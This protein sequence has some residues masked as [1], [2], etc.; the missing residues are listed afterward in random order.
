MSDQTNNA[1]NGDD[2][3]SWSPWNNPSV[4]AA[5]ADGRPPEDIILID[6]PDCGLPGHYNQGSHFTCRNC[7]EIFTC[8]TEEEEPPLVGRW[9]RLG[10]E[11]SLADFDLDPMSED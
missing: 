4:K 3:H 5:L 2:T 11:Y 8:L 1:S 6:C 10:A 9:L 7:G